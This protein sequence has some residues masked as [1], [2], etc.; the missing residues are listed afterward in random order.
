MSLFC[1]VLFCF[2][3]FTTRTHSDTTFEIERKKELNLV[4]IEGVKKNKQAERQ[5]K[6]PFKSCCLFFN[7]LY[8]ILTRKSRIQNINSEFVKYLLEYLQLTKK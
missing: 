4:I 1:F 5:T 2:F 6:S 3:A 7:A 8:L